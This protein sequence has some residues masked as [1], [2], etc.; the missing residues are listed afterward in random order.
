M[1][2]KLHTAFTYIR[3]HKQTL[4]TTIISVIGVVVLVGLFIYNQPKGPQID[5]KP[6]QA[7]DMLTPDKAMDILGD[8]IINTETNKPVIS[9]NTATSRCGYTDKN[10]NSDEMVEASIAVQSAINDKG[11]AQNKADFNARKETTQNKQLVTE[12]GDDAYFDQD[13]GLLNI[14]RGKQWIMI[15][16]G[17]GQGPEPKPLADIVT[18]AHDI[19]N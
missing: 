16:Y 6:V 17:V 19:L 13:S 8:K 10:I 9:G 18:L 3:E 5:Y 12:V 15:S 4:G 7:C 1:K 11:V 2:D 14:L